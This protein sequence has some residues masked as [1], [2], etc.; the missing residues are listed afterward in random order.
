MENLTGQ[1]EGRELSGLGPGGP[2]GGGGRSL[3]ASG[4]RGEP[5]C[6]VSGDA[7]SG[8]GQGRGHTPENPA[9]FAA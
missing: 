2:I 6:M 8:R 1:A 9:G 5:G 7:M 4:S 3:A